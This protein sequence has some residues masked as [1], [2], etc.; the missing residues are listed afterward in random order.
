V[1]AGE[2][3]DDGEGF[4][5]QDLDAAFRLL[6]ARAVKKVRATSDAALVVVVDEIFQN[7][8][9][10]GYKGVDAGVCRRKV[11]VRVADRRRQGWIYE[12]R[13]AEP[14]SRPPTGMTSAARRVIRRAADADRALRSQV[15]R[16]PLP[17]GR[18]LG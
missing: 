9:S 10:Q 8:V 13:A 3:H 14:A 6:D 1:H 11:Q 18:R 16:R 12:P 17:G 4:F 5:G 15:R 7:V 2:V